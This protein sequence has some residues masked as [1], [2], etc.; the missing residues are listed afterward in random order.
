NAEL[1]A[2]QEKISD[3]LSRDFLGEQV[4]VL[5]EGPSKKAHLNSTDA[6][7]NPQL[8]ARTATDYIVVFNGPESLAGR[9][10][11]VKI[12]RTSPLTLFGEPV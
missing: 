10:A 2:M 3:E 7:D 12:I 9:F 11:D 5:V 8:A 4:K 6:A 1:L